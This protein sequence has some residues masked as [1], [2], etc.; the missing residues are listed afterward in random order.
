MDESGLCAS[1]EFLTERIRSGHLNLEELDLRR[2]AEASYDAVEEA[3]LGFLP[4]NDE[5]F[6]AASDRLTIE[7]WPTDEDFLDWIDAFS[8]AM[9]LLSELDGP[10]RED[11]GS[12]YPF[13]DIFLWI[14]EY[15]RRNVDGDFDRLSERAVRD[16]EEHLLERLV[17]VGAQALHLDYVS[18]VAERAPAVVAADRL[19]PEETRWYDRYVANFYD[20]RATEFFEEFPVLARLVTV[21]ARQWGNVVS[22]FLSRVDDDYEAILSLLDTDDPGPVTRLRLGA[23]DPHDGGRTVIVVEFESGDEVVYKPRDVEADLRFYEFRAWLGRE[24][25]DVPAFE[26]PEFRYRDSYAW[27]ERIESP[28]FSAMADV[29]AYY[30]R[31]GSLL[32]VLYLLDVTDCHLENLIAADPGPVIVDAETTCH[33]NV[34][35][36][37]LPRK[38]LGER[39]QENEV[40]ETVLNSAL[41]PYELEF[42]DHNMAALDAIEEQ[43]LDA[44]RREWFHVNTDAM[45]MEYS[46]PTAVPEENY[47]TIDG[48]PAGARQFVDELVEGFAAT[49]DAISRS[50]PAVERKVEDLFEGVTVRNVLQETLQYRL[51]LDTVSSPKYLRDGLRYEYKIRTERID[52]WEH[53]VGDRPDWVDE[54][55]DLETAAMV[56]RDIPRFTTVTDVDELRF[57]GETVEEGVFGTTGIEEVRAKVDSLSDADNRHHRGL[58]RACLGGSRLGEQ[59]RGES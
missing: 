15:S 10:P 16:L 8:D 26:E 53:R 41:L 21:V 1:S 54:V 40:R 30:E 42:H 13:E 43:S 20:D 31:A 44:P 6:E 56:E 52:R 9:E 5:D 45:D 7:T 58:I 29:E 28:A 34:P 23:G 33:V 4:P 39:L 36:S 25:D 17:D 2:P 48:D 32:C 27:I 51:L 35:M 3:V 38:N 14:V 49:Y 59:P 55:I 18:Y 50:K 46:T 11:T 22:E 57:R 19:S 37:E 12:E 47:P 24:F